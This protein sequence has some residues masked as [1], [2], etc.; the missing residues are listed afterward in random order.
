MLFL[1]HFLQLGT[2]DHI[3]MAHVVEG[4]RFPD[5]ILHISDHPFIYSRIIFQIYKFIEWY[6]CRGRR[7]SADHINQHLFE[8]KADQLWGTE[9]K[10]VFFDH[11]FCIRIVQRSSNTASCFCDQHSH[12][13]PLRISQFQQLFFKEFHTRGSTFKR[14]YHNIRSSISDSGQGMKFIWF[15]K[16]NLPVSQ[17][18][19]SVIS[20]YLG[21]SLVYT[22]KFPEVMTLPGKM[23]I[24]FVFKIMD[25]VNAFDMNIFIQIHTLKSHE[26]VTS[27][28]ERFVQLYT[29]KERKTR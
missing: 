21:F 3:I 13:I 16:N 6:S 25:C 4:N 22:L 23:K 12:Q 19:D 9:H 20:P 29:K 10:L 27:P 24:A 5:M 11:F 2:S 8:I 14:N 17:M 15:M 28:N 26:C 7:I 1:E 18:V